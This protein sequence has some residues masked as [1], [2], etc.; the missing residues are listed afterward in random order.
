MLL[1]DAVLGADKAALSAR[2]RCRL[3]TGPR[4]APP[5]SA[6]PPR[7]RSFHSHVP[8]GDLEGGSALCMDSLG[9]PSTARFASNEP[10][11]PNPV[12]PSVVRLARSNPLLVIDPSGARNLRAA[13]G[14]PGLR[15]CP[16]PALQDRAAF[17]ASLQTLLRW[18]ID[19]ALVS[20][21]EP[22]IGDGGRQINDDL[23]AFAETW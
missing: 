4:R 8:L 9:P 14:R 11:G 16:S 12:S 17:E 3:G 20:H 10:S 21:G 22:V 23:R 1:L 7:G 6:R 15:V 18:P 13:A 5:A 19:H 2:S